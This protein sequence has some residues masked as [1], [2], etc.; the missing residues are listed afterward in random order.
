MVLKYIILGFFVKI[1]TGFDD[2]ITHI[3]VIASLTKTKIGKIAFSIGT[4]IAIIL[5]IITSIVFSTVLK[6]TPYYRYIAAG[7]VFGLA[8]AIY[9]DVLVHRPRTK[10]EKR[11]LKF[12]K[13]S[14]KRFTQLVG[15]GFIASFATVLDDIIAYSPLFLRDSITRIYVIVGILTATILEIILVIYFAEKISKIKYKEEI[16]GIGLVLLGI[17]IL[18]GII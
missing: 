3:P 11:L 18:I 14:V 13:I 1:I 9:F 6:I 8:I 5:A 16:A 15:I 12:Q 4:L 17:L 2:A 10:A 7:L